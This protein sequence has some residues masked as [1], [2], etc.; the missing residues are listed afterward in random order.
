M[1]NESKPP[2]RALKYPKDCEQFGLCYGGLEGKYQLVGFDW[3]EDD[4]GQVAW[5]GNHLIVHVEST[6]LVSDECMT[7]SEGDSGKLVGQ[8]WIDL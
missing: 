8:L 3:S 6:E 7:E 4:V 2:A 1:T 5:V